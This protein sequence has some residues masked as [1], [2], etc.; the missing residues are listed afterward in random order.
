MSKV[1]TDKIS[2]KITLASIFKCNWLHPDPGC[3]DG[4]SNFKKAVFFFRTVSY[5]R[6]TVLTPLAMDLVE[7]HV[8]RPVQ[9]YGRL[10]L[11]FL[12]ERFSP[13]IYI[14]CSIELT[15]S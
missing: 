11:K 1:Q 15:K 10:K 3:A 8:E 13:C 7:V 4:R 9:R 6:G 12:C 5:L 14:F 2:L